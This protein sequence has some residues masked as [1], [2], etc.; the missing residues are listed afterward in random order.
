MK[1]N[2][3]YDVE[4]TRKMSI[5]LY[6]LIPECAA[7]NKRIRAAYEAMDDFAVKHKVKEKQ[8][9]ALLYRKYATLIAAFDS[10]V[11][12][13]DA[14]AHKHRLADT[15]A[16][17]K[18]YGLE[19]EKRYLY[20]LWNLTG[21]L[22]IN[23]EGYLLFVTD[24]VGTWPLTLRFSDFDKLVR[25]DAVKIHDVRTVVHKEGTTI[26]NIPALERAR[27]ACTGRFPE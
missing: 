2:D 8:L 7:L 17:V 14:L 9:P 10:L 15:Q 19:I 4:W 12:E 26:T 16:L 6:D 25:T 13:R 20:T 21:T 22:Y 27:M 5:N 24:D 11:R 18:E 3:T 1:P 23:E